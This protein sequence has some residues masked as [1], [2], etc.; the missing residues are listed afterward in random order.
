MS[1]CHLRLLGL[2]ANNSAKEVDAQECT[3]LISHERKVED[4]ASEIKPDYLS[5]PGRAAR[6]RLVL[7]LSGAAAG[8]GAEEHGTSGRIVMG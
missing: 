6:G 7:Q 3:A 5:V 4:D 1:L 2:G 8:R